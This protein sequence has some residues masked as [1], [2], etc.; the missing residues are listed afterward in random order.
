HNGIKNNFAED[1]KIADGGNHVIAIGNCA[2]TLTTTF[3]KKLPFTTCGQQL[4]S[5]GTAVMQG[6]L[7]SDAGIL[8]AQQCC[9]TS[10]GVL[11]A[12]LL[13]RRRAVLLEKSTASAVTTTISNLYMCPDDW[14]PEEPLE[15]G[16]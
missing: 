11:R 16:K 6:M 10:S 4:E 9:R 5:A 15:M 13:V 3:C 12:N 2:T 1:G 14:D 7:P 8:G